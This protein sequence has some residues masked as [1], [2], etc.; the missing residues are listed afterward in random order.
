MTLYLL[1]YC[2]QFFTKATPNGR[3][4]PKPSVYLHLDV[5]SVEKWG[6]RPSKTCAV[7]Y[8]SIKGL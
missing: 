2:Q 8:Q 4:Q 6:H 7:C 3:T 1:G 5:L